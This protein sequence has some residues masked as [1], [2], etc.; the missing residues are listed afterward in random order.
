MRGN[1][2]LRPFEFNLKIHRPVN[3]L[4]IV[5]LGLILLGCE[6]K[7]EEQTSDTKSEPRPNIIL[8]VADDLGYSDIGSYGGEIS[9]PNLDELAQEGVR[10]SNMHNAGMCV[11]SRA[12]MLTGQWWPRVGF[13]IE[14]GSN[15]AQVLKKDGYRTGLIGKWHLKGEPNNKGFDHFFGF[16]GG[17]SSYFNGSPD[18]RLNKEKYDDFDNGFY[19][20]DAFSK[21]A[22]DFVNKNDPSQPFFLYLSYQ[23]P[24]NPLQAPKEDIEKY[25]GSYLKGWQVV[26]EARIENQIKMDLIQPE[27]PLPDYPENLPAWNSLTPQQKDLEDLRMSVYAAMVERMDTGIGQLM[28]AL[29]A[30][31]QDKRTLVIFLSDNGTDSFSVMDAAMLDKGL[32]PGDAGSNYQPGTGWAYASVAPKRLYKIS[33]HGGGVKT[34]AITWWPETIE[35][36]KSIHMEPLHVVDIM[37]TI[38]EVS[39]SLKSS[40]NKESNNFFAGKSFLPLLKG[41]DWKRDAPMYFQFIDNRAIRTEQWSLLE[42]DGNGWELYDN[43]KD[44]LETNDLANENPAKVS[45]L[46]KDWLEW[47]KSEGGNLDYQPESTSESPHYQPQGDRGSGDMYVP[48]AMPDTLRL[49]Y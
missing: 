17:F 34:G 16:L 7:Q 39:G 36:N 8:I 3:F 5:L 41:D 46:E 32:L 47:W 22:V 37:P 44:P 28:A 24:H 13:G 40:N 18:Y 29:K 4:F 2:R 9:T 10:L 25:R 20:T 30:N 26:R 33:Q 23:A 49:K 48:T 31:G 15:I 38:L 1:K 43:T 12:S 19:S 35:K 14:K 21:N 42:I 6:E 27:T 11:I 45:E